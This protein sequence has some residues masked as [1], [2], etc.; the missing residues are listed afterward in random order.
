MPVIEQSCSKPS[1]LSTNFVAVYGLPTRGKSTLSLALSKANGFLPVHADRI[2]KYKLFPLLENRNMFLVNPGHPRREHF[3][4]RKYVDST[5]YDHDL[6][7]SLLAEELSQRLQ[8]SPNVH[9]VLLDGY[10]FKHHERIFADLNI[11]SERTMTLEA[12]LID[13]RYMVE[14]F[15]VTGRR[16]DQVL[17]HIRDS[18]RS[19]CLK[20]TIP[21][22]KYQSFQTLGIP[23]IGSRVPD[24]DT[25]A[26]YDASQLDKFVGPQDRFADIGCNAGYYCF[27]IADKTK[28][29]IVGVDSSR[30]WL[31]IASHI[32]NSIF[33]RDNIRFVHS[34][35]VE[36]LSKGAEMFD[37]IHCASTYHYFRKRQ[38]GFLRAAHR[39]LSPDGRLVLEVE[40]SD[41]GPEPEIIRRARDVDTIP[42]SF[43]NRAAFLDQIRD[44]F[45]IEAE[46]GSVFQRGSLYPRTYFHLRPAG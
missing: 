7:T 16:Y 22:S 42:C 24:S 26:K 14:G 32:N 10:V 8:E 1:A 5:F 38:V 33:L 15:D 13:G 31:E 3:S 46:Y 9:I 34:E 44:L 4:I 28:G 25:A 20:T 43:P 36:Y 19:K 11:S 23:Q 12:R 2:F 37:V 21:K 18:F 40:L 27:R 30:R 41:A 39:A 17:A 29:T 45:H 6:F 35:A